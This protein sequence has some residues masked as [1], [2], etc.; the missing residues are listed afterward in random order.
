MQFKCEDWKWKCKFLDGVIILVVRK[1]PHLNI[2]CEHE[3]S[4][5]L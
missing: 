3:L 4:K 1:R 2:T 5:E